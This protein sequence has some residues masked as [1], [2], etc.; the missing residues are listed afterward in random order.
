MQKRKL[1]LLLIFFIPVLT[2]AQNLS[3]ERDTNVVRLNFGT[4]EYEE[5]LLSIRCADSKCLYDTTYYFS[6][7]LMGGSWIFKYPR[8]LY[9][10]CYSFRFFIPVHNDPIDKHSISFEQHIDND[11][12]RAPQYLFDNVDTVIINAGQKIKTNTFQDEKL[13]DDVYFL[14]NI[15]DKEFLSSVELVANRGFITSITEPDYEEI[16]NLYA[17]TVQKYPDSQSLIRFLFMLKQQYHTRDDVQKI[18][19]NFSDQQKQSYFGIRIQEF[20]SDSVF[21]F[22][23]ILL[24]AWDTEILEPIIK[25]FSKIN[26]VIFSASWCGPCIAEIPVLKKVAEELSNKIEMVYVSMDETTTVNAWKELMIDKEITWRSVLG[27]NN[28]KEIKEQF[29]IPSYPTILMVYPNGRYEEIDVRY[30]GDLKKLYDITG[31]Q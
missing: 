3:Q 8:S 24:P 6:G 26:L 20:L 28:L 31:K 16:I 23:N 29:H 25:D 22:T 12:I 14:N 13:L 11:T 9:E 27:A 19:D 2:G 30:D 5:V 15:T 7:T 10:K 1:F 18:Y 17:K 21:N 4:N